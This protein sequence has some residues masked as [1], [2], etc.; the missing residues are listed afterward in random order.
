MEVHTNRLFQG[1]SK[2]I[3]QTHFLSHLPPT[4]LSIRASIIYELLNGEDFMHI[5]ADNKT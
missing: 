2:K 4:H 1:A 5:P 3:H